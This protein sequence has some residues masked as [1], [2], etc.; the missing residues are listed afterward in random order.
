IGT[1][2]P[3]N[4]RWGAEGGAEELTDFRGTFI[5]L[6]VSEGQRQDWDDPR[7][8]LEALY[9]DKDTY[10]ERVRAAT[11]DLAGEGF[12]LGSDAATAVLMAEERWE[13]LMGRGG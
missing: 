4:L 3:W 1:Y 10:L 12:L 6:S 13:W 5:P 7:P 11:R 8:S 2:A 9:P